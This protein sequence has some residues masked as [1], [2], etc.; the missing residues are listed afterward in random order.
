MPRAKPRQATT[1]EKAIRRA[2][3]EETVALQAEI[4]Q[5]D[6]TI[7]QLRGLLANIA[8]IAQS[9]P[10]GVEPVRLPAPPLPPVEEATIPE[11]PA[12]DLANE[13]Q[14]GS[15]RWV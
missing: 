4:R 15:G 11:G 6:A 12:G 10:P 9:A 2:I 5:K 3:E 13:D 8:A 7:A 1:A 14:M